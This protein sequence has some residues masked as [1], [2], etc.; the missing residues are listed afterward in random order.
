MDNFKHE[1]H[2]GDT[3]GGMYINDEPLSN[4]PLTRAEAIS[5]GFKLASALRSGELKLV[6]RNIYRPPDWEFN[7]HDAARSLSAAS[8]G[9]WISHGTAAV[10]YQFLLPPWMSESNELHMSKPRTLPQPRRKGIESHNVRAFPDEVVFDMDLWI[11]T[12]ERTWLDLAR[13]LPLPN[14]V[15]IGDQLIRMP[16][17]EFEGRSDPFTTLGRLRCLLDRH[18]NMQGI[19]RARQALDLMRVGSDSSPE[20]LL[21]LAIVAAGLPEPELQ[22][23]L[24]SSRTAPSA[25][26]GYR[27]R[28]IA[29]QY[30]G[31]HHLT[32]EQR[33]KDRR[34]DMAFEAAGWTV[35]KFTA[36]DYRDGFENAVRRIRSALRAPAV[37]PTVRSGFKNDM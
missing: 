10:L 14:L 20:S 6:S 35:L 28:R 21:R 30:D 15:C 1:R 9:A 25:D 23:R 2:I 33:F 26:A 37:D 27:S 7:L 31:D 3:I 22:I 5:R 4:G 11:S 32:D 18:K 16:R 36:E 24:N 29:L 19:V 13:E 34:R 8:P 17:P 12:R